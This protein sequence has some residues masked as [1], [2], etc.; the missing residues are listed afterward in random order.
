MRFHDEVTGYITMVHMHAVLL[1]DS[2]NE[3]NFQYVQKQV[4]PVCWIQIYLKFEETHK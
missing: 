4:N 2:S 1:E 3:R